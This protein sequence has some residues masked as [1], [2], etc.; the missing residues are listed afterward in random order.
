[1][2]LVKN[3]NIL[4]NLF[5]FQKGLDMMFDGILDKKEEP[6]ILVQKLKSLPNLVPFKKA[7]IW[8][9]IKFLI[10]MLKVFLDYKNG[11]YFKINKN[12]CIFLGVNC[13]YKIA[14]IFVFS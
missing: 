4:P 9:W 13:Y 12:I 2:T 14:K 8:G 10:K 5:L 1:M 6:M 7:S 11:T 3:L